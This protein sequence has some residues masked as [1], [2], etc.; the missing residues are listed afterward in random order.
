MIWGSEA[1][2]NLWRDLDRVSHGYAARPFVI[3]PISIAATNLLAAGARQLVGSATFNLT[4][5]LYIN[6]GLS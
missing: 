5:Q 3:K 6:D 4:N 2:S 1:F